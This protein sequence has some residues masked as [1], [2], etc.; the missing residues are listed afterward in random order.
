[1]DKLQSEAVDRSVGSKVRQ[2]RK[3][4]KISQ[5]TLANSINLTF[6]QV[7]KYER[8][9]NRISASKLHQIACF[10][11]VPISYFFEDMPQ[12]IEVGL[13]IAGKDESCIWIFFSSSEGMELARLFPK[14]ENKQQ[15]RKLLDLVKSMAG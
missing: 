10:L 9:S 6:Q 15:R 13:Q 12:E 4:M 14:I 7:Q 5:Q 3:E 8:G 11:Q 2:R 1:M